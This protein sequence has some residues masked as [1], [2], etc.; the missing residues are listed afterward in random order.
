MTTTIPQEA[1]SEILKELERLPIAINK[2]RNKAG[3]GRSQTFGV[4][5][6]R[7]L[8]PDASRMNW[9]RPYL[10]HL[11]L[12]FGRKYVPFSFTSITVNQNYQAS[13]HYDKNNKGVSFLVGF[14]DYTEGHLKIH[15]GDL[16]GTHDINCKPIIADFSKILHEVEAFQGQ[17]YS[18]VFYNF[19]N[20]KSIVLPKFEVKEEGG[21]WF[22]Y[23]DNQKI[24]AKEGLPHPL[25][26]RKKNENTMIQSAP[27]SFTVSFD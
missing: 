8:P 21:K 6:R 17:R 11:L 25:R 27:I 10:Y 26:N 1:F 9:L 15:E 22:F 24:T 12:E 2:Y 14:G 3:D 4:V 20:K 18:L 23:R 5:G 7:C 16:K 13:P 19:E